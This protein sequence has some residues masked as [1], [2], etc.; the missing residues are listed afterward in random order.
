MSATP[1]TVIGPAPDNPSFIQGI[2]A[3]IG[4][5]DVIVIYIVAL[6]VWILFFLSYI[7]GIYSQWYLNLRQSGF[8]TWIPRLAWVVAG[9]LSYVGSY[10]LWRNSK[11]E[12]AGKYL[13]ITVL[14]IVGN[15]ILLA[16]SVALYQGHNIGLA[17]WLSGILFVYQAGLFLIVWHL[18]PV[19]AI[20]S[21]P[22]LAL[23][24]YLL[25]TMVHLAALNNEVL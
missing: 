4:N 8:N 1:I 7:P 22:L 9:I 17:A 15:F 18:S 6:V 11:P 2:V 23:Y 19:A 25:Y 14:Y 10:L 16:W 24:L 5:P 21:L 3:R 12:E 20:F 13:A